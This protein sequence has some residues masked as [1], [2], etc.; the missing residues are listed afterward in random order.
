MLVLLKDEEDLRKIFRFNDMYCHLYVSR[1]NKVVNGATPPLLQGILLNLNETFSVILPRSCSFINKV[2]FFGRLVDSDPTLNIASNSK[3]VSKNW[4]FCLWI[5][6]Y[7]EIIE[8][9]PTVESYGLSNKVTEV[10]VQQRTSS[11]YQN[12]NYWKWSNVSSVS[13]FQDAVYEMSLVGRFRY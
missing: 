12:F 13:D 10:D 11:K 3:N 6:L 1:K 5:R 9:S 4:N 7:M 8:N 2:L